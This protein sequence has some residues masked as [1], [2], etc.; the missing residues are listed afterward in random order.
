M[1]L[2]FKLDSKEAHQNSVRRVKFRDKSEARGT[3]Y[4]N[5]LCSDFVASFAPRPAAGGLTV[6]QVMYNLRECFKVL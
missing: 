4:F 5:L 2:S 1:W 6:V 3:Q